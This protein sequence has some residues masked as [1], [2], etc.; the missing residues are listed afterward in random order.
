MFPVQDLRPL[1]NPTKESEMIKHRRRH[2]PR[3]APGLMI[4]MLA[5]A[6]L[7]AMSQMSWA[8]SAHDYTLKKINGQA[9][10]LKQFRG[11]PIL[12]V[13]T[14]S[15]CGFT[16]Q[17]KSLQA[18]WERYQERGLVVVGVPSSDSG[19]QEPGSAQHIQ[20]FC[21][22]NYGVKFPLTAKQRVVGRE[23]HPLYHW[24]VSE[25]GAQH[26]PRWNFHKYLISSDGQVVGTWPSHVDPLAPEITR[27]IEGLLP[28]SSS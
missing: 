24:I 4:A 12:L 19:R 8:V 15:R 7:A 6:A 21:E 16:P 23:A 25:L 3:Y 5:F 1:P 27:V 22:L 10:P 28:K 2:D 13:N 18:L 14:A 20:Q 11:R 26:A 17:Y 9:L